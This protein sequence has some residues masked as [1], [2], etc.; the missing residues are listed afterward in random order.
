MGVVIASGRINTRYLRRHLTRERA[1]VSSMVGATGTLRLDPGGVATLQWTSAWRG[2]LMMHAHSLQAPHPF[3]VHDY[4]SIGLVDRGVTEIQCRGDVFHAGPGSV[5]LISPWEA[6]QEQNPSPGGFSLRALYPALGTMRR[7]LGIDGTVPL[8]R[9]EF[10]RPVVDDAAL[11]DQLDSLF[12]HLQRSPG[13][14][15]ES[16]VTDNVRMSLLRHLRPKHKLRRVLRST[17]AVDAIQAR[18]LRNTR[19]MTSMVELSGVTGMSRFHLS[20]AFRDRTGLPPYAYF[21][22]VRL[23]RANILMRQG[24]ALSEV[25]M[26]LG[27]SDQSHFHRQFRSQAA[28]TPGRYARALRAVFCANRGGEFS[29]SLRY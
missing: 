24:L 16:P 21:E 18:I 20:R 23:A 28:T 1:L 6:H 7:V 14:V 26:A 9:L 10:E 15:V 4:Y 2:V 29:P 22:Q 19:Q 25:A 11:A 27:F 17:R 3:H 5:I 8:E 13:A 12:A